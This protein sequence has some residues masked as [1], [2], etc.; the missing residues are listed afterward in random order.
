MRFRDLEEI[1][2]DLEQIKEQISV[3][4]KKENEKERNGE[5]FDYT[6]FHELCRKEDELKRE[7][8]TTERYNVKIGD[9]V[10]IHYYSD[11]HAGTIID[12][13]KNSITIQ[14]DKATLKSDWKPEFIPGG[15]AGHCIN[16]EDQEYVYERDDNGR[17]YKAYW[18]K[19]KGRFVADK[20]LSISNGRQEYYDYNF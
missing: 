18:S 7:Y 11:S 8:E 20:C 13:T 3:E 9:G 17:I 6:L 15:F 1:K 4:F 5:P 12:R 19:V 10:T 2:R 16:Q 14:Q